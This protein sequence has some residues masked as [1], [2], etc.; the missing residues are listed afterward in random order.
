MFLTIIYQIMVLFFAGM[1]IW[2]LYAVK[3]LGKKISC[4][5]VLV[6]LLLRLFLIR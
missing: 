5:V 6:P 3:D 4:C 1:F 2:N